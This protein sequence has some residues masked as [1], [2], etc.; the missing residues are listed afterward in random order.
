MWKCVCVWIGVVLWRGT[1]Y[2]T[3]CGDHRVGG[4]PP[5]LMYG[6]AVPAPL[7]V[8]TTRSSSSSPARSMGDALGR[9]LGAIGSTLLSSKSSA[10]R[11]TGLLN[12]G[13]GVWLL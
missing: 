4:C 13:S 5:V 3:S 2:R 10:S 12:C 8:D 11:A 1:T 6:G 7:V 9:F